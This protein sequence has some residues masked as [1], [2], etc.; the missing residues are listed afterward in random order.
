M[1]VFGRG[2]GWEDVTGMGQGCWEGELRGQD[3][4]RPGSSR[5]MRES[6]K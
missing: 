3:L 2:V 6:E 4:E 5:R 1:S